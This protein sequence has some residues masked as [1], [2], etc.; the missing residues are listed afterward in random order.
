MSCRLVPGL[1]DGAT[2]GRRWRR[3]FGD[4]GAKPVGGRTL[5]VHFGD[6]TFVDDG[7]QWVSLGQLR[8]KPVAVGGSYERGVVAAASCEARKFGVRSAMPSVTARW[9][10]PDL[11]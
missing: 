9:K 5:S 7:G 8:G 1:V 2:P 4:R 11:I 6:R 10:C 3:R